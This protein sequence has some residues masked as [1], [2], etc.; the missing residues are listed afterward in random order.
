M[1]DPKLL[2]WGGSST[3]DDRSPFSSRDWWWLMMMARLNPGVNEQRASTELDVLFQESISA[4]ATSSVRPETTP[5]I[6]LKPASKGLSFLRSQ[7][8]R[9]LQILM[10]VVALVLLIACANVATLLVGRS[11]ARQKE[12]AVRLSLGASRPRLL[13]QLLTESVLLAGLGGAVGILFARWGSRVLVVLMSSGGEPFHFETQLDAKVL[14]FTAAV[15]VLTGI[16]FGLVPAL[17]TTR[18]ELT[19]ALKIGASAI[20]FV[21]QRTRL[22]LGKTLVVS[23]VALSLLLLIAAGLFVR[24]L[25][26]LQNENL[27][28]NQHQLLLFALDPTKNGYSG[29]RLID[30]YGQLLQRLQALPGATNATMSANALVSGVQS[31]W[32]V[33]IEGSQ[34]RSRAGYGRGLEQRR[35]IV[36]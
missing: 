22:A 26:N 3:P 33:S 35:A 23:Q 2:P 19:P 36:F 24:T 32:P 12:V 28:F 25:Q 17:G 7:F 29:Q 6:E 13:Q 10:V 1:D 15:S 27:G 21:T 20:A 11:T 5:H 4:A 9:P 30:F 14:G 18:V 34:S 31:H 8:S 16:L